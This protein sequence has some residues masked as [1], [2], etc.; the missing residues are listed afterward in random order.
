LLK[1]AS[2]E[3]IAAV[4]LAND[5][6][7]SARDLIELVRYPSGALPDDVSVLLARRS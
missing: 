2:A 3:R 7:T 4:A 6:E 1:Y 5:L